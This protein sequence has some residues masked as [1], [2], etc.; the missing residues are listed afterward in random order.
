M[1]KAQPKDKEQVV[2]MLTL[3]FDANKS[4]NY[5]IPQDHRRTERITRL[6][7]YSFDY[8]RLFGEVY[9][10]DDRQACALIVHP[11]KVK[12]SLPSIRLDLRL[13]IKCIGLKNIRKVVQREAVIKKL[14]PKDPFCYLWFIGTAPDV[15]HKGIGT[16]LLKSL[17]DQCEKEALP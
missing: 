8:C 13:I 4:V 2:R 5:I 15:Q 10:S 14:H 17:L 12:T 6:M 11:H 7:E 1:R 16:T 3:C 9:L